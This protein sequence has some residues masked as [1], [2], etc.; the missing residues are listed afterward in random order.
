MRAV[1]F[2]VDCE[3]TSWSESCKRN[4]SKSI[5]CLLGIF[6]FSQS[7]LYSMWDWTIVKSMKCVI[8]LHFHLVHFVDSTHIHIV[9]TD[10]LW[11][12]N[13]NLL[14]RNL[15]K[16]NSFIDLSHANV[17]RCEGDT[18]IVVPFDTDH[19]SIRAHYL[20]GASSPIFFHFGVRWKWW[21]CKSI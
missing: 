1:R 4:A 16:T 18:F 10:D 21:L 6:D 9:V 19:L 5:T 13:R 3:Y 14:F 12:T 11:T 15:V 20:L 17:I 2:V 8:I 7:I